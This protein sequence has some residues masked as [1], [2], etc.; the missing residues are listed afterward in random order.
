MKTPI[1]LLLFFVFLGP[2]SSHALNCGSKWVEAGE[3]KVEVLMK[4]GEPLLIEKYHERDVVYRDFLGVIKGKDVHTYV[5]IW[6]YNFGANR[7]LYFLRF[8]ND[9]LSNIEEGVRG[10]NGPLP[11]RPVPSCGQWVQYGD[12]K[13]D[14]LMKCGPPTL[15]DEKVEE[16]YHSIFSDRD[17]LFAEQNSYRTIEDWTYNFGPNHF[18]YFIRLE[19][20]RVRRI[21]SGT[22]GY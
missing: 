9:R 12:R 1:F 2:Q 17:R 19:N 13:I 22:Y 21:E 11:S 7:F 10:F 4:C 6:T 8:V 14:V 15:K 16:Q 3:R 20:G 18:L 5:E